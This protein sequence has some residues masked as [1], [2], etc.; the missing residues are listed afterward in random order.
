MKS[1]RNRCLNELKSLTRRT[2]YSFSTYISEE[3]LE[4][5]D[6][7]FMDE[8]HPWEHLSSMNWR[9]TDAMYR[10]VA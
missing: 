10:P 3:N 1:V 4:F 9:T 8:N 7:L 2:E 5:L 6:T